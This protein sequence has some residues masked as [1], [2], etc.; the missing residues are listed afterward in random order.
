MMT[1]VMSEPSEFLEPAAEREPVPKKLRQS[2]LVA[3]VVA[4]AVIAAGIYEAI[5]VIRGPS[6]H[7]GTPPPAA[8]ALTPDEKAYYDYV[9]PRLHDLVAE[10]DLLAEMGSQKSRNIIVL[11]R[12]YTR[13]SDLID[14]IQ[15]YQASHPLPARFA[16]AAT[17]LAAGVAEVN[18]A[19]SNAESAFYKLQFA[20]LGELLAEFKGGAQTVNEAAAMLDRLGGGS[21]VAL[22]AA[23]P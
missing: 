3:G 8:A 14:E 10:L 7:P 12:H 16:P 6:V 18:A 21:P 4:L 19:M 13:A 2:W 5:G 22:G 17:P 20:K 9:A 15:T 1:S 23:T 11:E